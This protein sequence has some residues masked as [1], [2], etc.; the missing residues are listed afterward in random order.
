M[1]MRKI[2]LLVVDDEKD[3][4]KFVKLIFKK[5]GFLVYSAFSGEA[6]IRIARRTKPDI[7]LLDIYL[8]KGID[9][10]ETLKGIS[11]VALY[12]KCIMVTWDKA[13]DKIKE[14]RREGAVSYLV[15]PLTIEQLLKVVS[16]VVKG[17]RKRG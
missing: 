1:A 8:K 11:K 3:I 10:L 5:K 16:R 4:C 6:A 14:A 9:G 2:K 15:K 17:L 7:A 13:E 12:C